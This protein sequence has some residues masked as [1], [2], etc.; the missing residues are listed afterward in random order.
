HGVAVSSGTAALEIILRYVG[1]E[2]REVVVPANTFYATAGAV[3][4]AGGTPVFADV[5]AETFAVS[6]ATLEEVLSERT[7]AV[8]LVHIA[9]V[10]TPEVD[11]IAELCRQRGVALVED[12]AHAHGCSLD[13]RHAGSF[14]LAGAFSFYPTKVMTTGE[15]GMIVTTEDSLEQEARIYRDQGKAGFL[16]NDHVRMGYA[17][18]MSEL[19]AAVGIVH[20]ERL[21]QAIAVRRT[22][23]DRY[24][25]ALGGLDGIDILHPAPGG[26]TNYYK[27]VA[28]LPAGAER[29]LLKKSLRDDFN[30]SLSG[31]VYDSP[32]HHQEVMRPFVRGP[33]PVAEDICARH[34]CLPVMSDMT[35]AE[36]DYVIESFTRAYEAL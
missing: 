30:V 24:D 25:A 33:L 36:V 1:V 16:G 28:L 26:V 35:D 13:G 20:L 21:D 17:W 7:A 15:G 6:R 12:A 22:V 31:E 32:L 2:G 29:A 11:E 19:G 5:S 18:R 27:Y 14:G 9:G 8:V 10:I 34:V 23:A 4:H 3:V